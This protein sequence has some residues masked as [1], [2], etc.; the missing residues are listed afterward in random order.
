VLTFNMV[1]YNE[2]LNYSQSSGLEQMMLYLGYAVSALTLL[3]LLLSIALHK[4][5]G[6]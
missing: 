4:M 2:P 6:L 1:G 5:V 3:Q